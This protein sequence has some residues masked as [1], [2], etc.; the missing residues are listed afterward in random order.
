MDEYELF[1]TNNG[2]YLLDI[3]GANEYALDRENALVALEILKKYSIPILGGDVLL[4]N[5]KKFEYTMPNWSIDQTYESD[6]E[7]TK[8]SLDY[9]EKFIKNHPVKSALFVIVIPRKELKGSVPF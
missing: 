5:G 4:F 8:S 3:L 6:Q 1:I 7:Y 9:A 2:L